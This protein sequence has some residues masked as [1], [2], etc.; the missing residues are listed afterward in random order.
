VNSAE[1][2]LKYGALDNEGFVSLLYQNVLG[3][4]PDAAGLNNWV[5]QLENGTSRAQVLLGFSE[6]AEFKVS[7]T[8]ALDNFMRM[9]ELTWI[10]VIEGGAGNDTMNANTGGDIFIFRQGEGGNDLIHGFEPWDELQFSGF[11]YRNGS[12]AMAHMEQS[13]PSVVFRDQGQAITFLNTSMA[14]MR[15]VL[16]NVS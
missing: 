5:T 9:A 13:G 12:D 15:R 1:F 11:G 2:Q 8:P 7:T 6:S 4:A 10:D 16:Y 14:E 3:R